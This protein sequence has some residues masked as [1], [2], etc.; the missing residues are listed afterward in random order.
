MPSG[1]VARIRAARPGAVRTGP[2]FAPLGPAPS[3]PVIRIHSARRDGGL[4]RKDAL[5]VGPK[6]GAKHRA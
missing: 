6:A 1:S 4:E 2:A 5:E 3:G